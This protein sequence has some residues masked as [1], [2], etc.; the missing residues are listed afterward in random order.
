V[1]R[2]REE[3]I[4]I[5]AK[6]ELLRMGP[7]GRPMPKET[8]SRPL[9]NE[10]REFIESERVLCKLDFKYFAERYC[11][12]DRD[13]GV[14]RLSG[15]GPAPFLNSQNRIV[16]L[17]GRREEE[18]HEEQKKY[19]RTDGI[20]AYVIKCRQITA[21]MTARMMTLHRMLFYPG[22]RSLAASIDAERIGELYLRDQRIID[23]LPWWLSQKLVANV[24]DEEVVF[25]KPNH[26]RISYQAENQQQGRGGLGV[27]TQVDVS[28]LTEVALWQNPKFIK[29]SFVP[30]MPKAITT[31]HLQESTSN[32]MGGDWHECT[33][34]ARHRREGFE[35]WVYIFIPWYFNVGKWTKNAHPDWNPG[36]ATLK[37]AALIERTSSEF[38]DG[39][40][41]RPTREQLAW[42]ETTRAEHIASGD[43]AIFLTNYP[44]T[45]EQSFQNPSQGAL[46]PDLIEW[47]EANTGAG[48]VAYDYDVAAA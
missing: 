46:P 30:A 11:S 31:L 13:P 18:C 21:T 6:L 9:V 20:R 10:E 23:G 26:S 7:D 40:V 8:L 44:A 34:N 28:H 42:W 38:F 47:M 33:E 36:E 4:A 22:T 19:G 45:P 12:I 24:K 48:G 17:L 27:G 5:A 16:E 39:K 25:D 1:R 3:C 35:D 15:V 14:G 37:H 41:Y 2:P 32:G 29:F 43:L